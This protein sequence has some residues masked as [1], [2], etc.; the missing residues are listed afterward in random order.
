MEEHWDSWTAEPWGLRKQSIR[1]RQLCPVLPWPGQVSIKISWS[2]RCSGHMHTIIS[3]FLWLHRKFKCKCETDFLKSLF[4]FIIHNIAL[5]LASC[6]WCCS[7]QNAQWNTRNAETG[8]YWCENNCTEQCRR[9]LFQNP[10]NLFGFF[11]RL[12]LLVLL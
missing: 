2:E 4:S 10:V 5:L 12:Y 1:I 6:G 7:L 3:S 11:F 8:T 9:G